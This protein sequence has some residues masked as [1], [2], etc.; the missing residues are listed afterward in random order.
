MWKLGLSLFC[1]CFFTAILIAQEKVRPNII[2]IMVDDMGYAD[3][4]CYGRK[5]YKTPHI[6][7]LAAEGIRF[8][9]AYSAANWS[10]WGVL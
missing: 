10:I 2:Y 7:Q 3:L 8:T 4:S 6:D 1:C 9:N 5:D